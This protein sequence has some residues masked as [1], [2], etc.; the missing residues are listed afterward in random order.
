[1]STDEINRNAW[2]NVDMSQSDQYKIL[3]L[4]NIASLGLERFPRDR[5]RC[6]GDF[7]DPHAILVR[8]ANLLSLAPNPNLLAV[9]RAG[10]GT[11]NIDGPNLVI[12]EPPQSP[13]K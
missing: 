9:G 7:D 3:T 5:Y 6:G 1:M 13:F 10:A 8:S 4:N 11:N 12:H 2:V